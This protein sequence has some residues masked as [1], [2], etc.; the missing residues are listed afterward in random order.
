MTPKGPLNVQNR[1]LNVVFLS[2]YSRECVFLATRQDRFDFIVAHF[3]K[4]AVELSRNRR[5]HLG[6][7]FSLTFFRIPPPLG[8]QYA[9]DFVVA[10]LLK[11]AVKLPYGPK[12]R[13]FDKADPS[14]HLP[15]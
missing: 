10:Y 11:I 6:S 4:V 5:G 14:V 7:P 2:F 8:V 13:A 3:S 12:I 9:L 1:C 15:A